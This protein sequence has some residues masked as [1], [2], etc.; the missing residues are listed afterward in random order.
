M[1]RSESFSTS[2]AKER[3]LVSQMIKLKIKLLEV[4]WLILL[5]SRS[6]PRRRPSLS[7]SRLKLGGQ[8]LRQRVKL[9]AALGHNRAATITNSKASKDRY[10]T[11][12]S[13]NFRTKDYQSALNHRPDKVLVGAVRLKATAMLLY[14]QADRTDKSSSDP[15]KAPTSW[16]AKDSKGKP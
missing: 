13:T 7:A 11:G 14:H 1:L 3:T 9:L 5:K 4:V 2:F 6:R 10:S 16:A 12:T 8:T 15:V